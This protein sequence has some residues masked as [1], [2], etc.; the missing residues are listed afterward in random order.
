LQE[1]HTENEVKT[2]NLI[3]KEEAKSILSSLSNKNEA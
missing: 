3:K 2:L 1:T